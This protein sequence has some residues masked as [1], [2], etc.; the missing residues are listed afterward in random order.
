MEKNNCYIF[1]EV[2][3]EKK[4]AQFSDEVQV[5]TIEPEPEQAYTLM[6]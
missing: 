6:R 5:E 2:K 4:T 3:T 1:F